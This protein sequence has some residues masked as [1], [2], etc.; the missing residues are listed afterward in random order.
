[1]QK[2]LLLTEAVL[3]VLIALAFVFSANGEVSRNLRI[4]ELL[5]AVSI[6]GVLSSSGAVFQ[7]VLLNPL[8]DPYIL[9]IG[10]SAVL[11]SAIGSFLNLNKEVLSCLAGVLTSATVCFL[12]DKIKNPY[13]LILFGVAVGAFTYSLLILLYAVAPSETIYDAVSFSLGYITP[14]EITKSLLFFL[15]SV[16]HTAVLLKVS[17]KIDA[18]SLGEELSYLSGVSFKEGTLILAFSSGIVSI[19]VSQVGIIGFIGIVV[20]NA[21]KLVG[22]TDFKNLGITATLTGALSVLVFHWISREVFRPEIL[23]VGVFTALFGTPIF[24]YLLTRSNKVA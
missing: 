6:G 13:R 15:L 10:S 11:G 19:L 21:L 14:T 22:I 2:K 7:K 18:L 24:V 5:L 16:V 1:M 4:S 8:A 17:R 23:P 20:P 3:T 9:G 12:S